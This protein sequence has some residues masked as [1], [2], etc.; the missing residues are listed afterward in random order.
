MIECLILRLTCLNRSI[1]LTFTSEDYI[2][3]DTGI[4]S[5]FSPSLLFLQM[6][7]KPHS[8]HDWCESRIARLYLLSVIDVH[9]KKETEHHTTAFAFF[10]FLFLLFSMED[11]SLVSYTLKY[12]HKPTDD[13]MR[14]SAVFLRAMLSFLDLTWKTSHTMDEKSQIPAPP[15]YSTSLRKGTDRDDVVLV[16]PRRFVAQRCS[17]E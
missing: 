6:A 2:C 11:L 13:P 12:E 5:C 14:I 9:L 7:L 4:W 8:L 3:T 17:V 10:P 16:F 15:A 1:Y